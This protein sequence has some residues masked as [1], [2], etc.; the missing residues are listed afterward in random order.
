MVELL[1]LDDKEKWNGYIAKL[2]FELQDIYYSPEYYSIYE[3]SD[4]GNAKCF[5][6]T[7]G[8]NIAIYPFLMNCINDLGYE[9][10]DRFYDIQGAYGY[11][12]ILSNDY[13]VTFVSRFQKEFL[14]FCT[15]KNII[16][17]FTRFNPVF[18]N[19]LKPFHLNPV[20]DQDNIILN[21]ASNN[22]PKTDYEHSTR[23]NINK[24]LRNNLQSIIIEGSNMNREYLDI[25]TDIYY[26]TMR[27]NDASDDYYYSANYFDQLISSVKSNCRFYFVLFEN[28]IISTE[29]VLFGKQI[30]YS[31]L[32]GT[33][34]E[35]FQF[36]PNDFLKDIIIR[37][38]KSEG[39]SYYC[40][41]GGSSGIVRYKKTFAKNGSC[42][43]YIGKKI[44][45]QTIYNALI[46][47]W[48]RK[49]P[50]SVQVNSKIL[51]KYR[52]Q[53]HIKAL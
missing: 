52:L 42:E 24:A 47:Q 33:L 6:I 3:A 5:V 49:N 1:T 13:S 21:L 17:E 28:K 25:F 39:K 4:F 29:L 16:A 34:E 43:F 8:T 14:N 48:E 12:G 18:R 40:L 20:F 10:N 45:N 19:N 44:H 46:E 36:R 32:G 2:P 22:I 35:F 15:Q 53:D 9:L 30:A 27:R 41:G 23:K 51:L 38:L 31:F 50:I 26:K 37:D 7:Q 11:N